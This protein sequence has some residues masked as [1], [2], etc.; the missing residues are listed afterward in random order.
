MRKCITVLCIIGILSFC[1]SGTGVSG[2]SAGP[3]YTKLVVA[4][5][6]T[7][8]SRKD[9]AMV[10]EKINAITEKEIG[11]TVEF[12]E[13]ST[14]SQYFAEAF[15][16]LST[17]EQ[18]DIMMAGFGSFMDCYVG[19]ELLPLDSLLEQYGQGIV[20]QVGEDKIHSCD[21]HGML[22][23][24]PVN[25]DYTQ[26][27]NCYIMRE[28]ILERYHLDPAAIKTEEDLEYVFEVVKQ[29]EPGMTML[30]SGTEPNNTLLSTNLEF[31]DTSSGISLT[32]CGEDGRLINAFE[33]EEYKNALQQVHRW[34]LKGYLDEE[35]FGVPENV[36]SKVA[37]GDLFAYAERKA[38]WSGE[39]ERFRIGDVNMVRISLEPGD[40][41]H[42][43]YA[44]LP[45]VITRNSISPEAAMKFL[46][47]VYTN[48]E[49]ENLLCY[50]VEGIHYKKTGDGHI[51]YVDEGIDNPF[52]WNSY[53]MPNQFI[54]YVWEGESLNFWEQVKNRNES[55]GEGPKMGFNFDYSNVAAEYAKVMDIY[56][57]YR[58]ILESGLDN[59]EEGIK[60][61]LNEMEESG[62]SLI[63]REEQKQFEDWCK[64]TGKE[65][66]N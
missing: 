11:I 42:R 49:I 30:S 40:L 6:F 60:K 51:T 1:I 5:P 50:G 38:A 2:S 33:S 12:P 15:L 29:N 57:D 54:T 16:M 34:Y 18:M 35:I 44:S 21:I 27:R 41:L 45:Y 7:G 43:G 13:F 39:S 56:S 14:S 31:L 61:M 26:Q 28:D 47:L 19:G 59:P 23:G 63:I 22:Y 37:R 3:Q 66:G 10:Q 55:A 53:N 24:I 46:N 4:I 17:P 52:R 9:V 20:E 36:Y 8:I 64:R 48:P 32:V 58:W 62:F 25:G 65:V